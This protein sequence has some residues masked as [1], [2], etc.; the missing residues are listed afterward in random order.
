MMATVMM[1]MMMM[2]MMMTG[3]TR[4]GEKGSYTVGGFGFLMRLL[5]IS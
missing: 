3:R 4:R 5:G 2:M 1:M